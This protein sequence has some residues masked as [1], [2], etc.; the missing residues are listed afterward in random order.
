MRKGIIHSTHYF[1][2]MLTAHG[3]EVRVSE[4]ICEITPIKLAGS[5][6][7]ED[8]IKNF[9]NILANTA[10]HIPELPRLFDEKPQEVF[11]QVQ[12]I[13]SNIPYWFC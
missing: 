12:F 7:I 8:F 10:K 4:N 1:I 6:V 11:R 13:A 9:A 2:Q 3:G 5:I